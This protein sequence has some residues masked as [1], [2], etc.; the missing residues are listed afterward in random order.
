[1]ITTIAN[2]VAEKSAFGR[3]GKADDEISGDAGF[4]D[5]ILAQFGQENIGFFKQILNVDTQSENI[6]EHYADF[7]ETNIRFLLSDISGLMNQINQLL[8]ES[9]ASD[10][11]INPEKIGSLLSFF[12]K[13][14][15]GIDNTFNTNLNARFKQALTELA[16]EESVVKNDTFDKN[17]NKLIV[18]D[19]S[20]QN[21]KTIKISSEALPSLD[22]LKKVFEQVQD[23]FKY[24]NNSRIGNIADKFSISY[25]LEKLSDL[26]NNAEENPAKLQNQLLKSFSEE[27]SGEKV[28]RYISSKGDNA[29]MMNVN[30]DSSNNSQ[31]SEQLV[32]NKLFNFSQNGESFDRPDQESTNFDTFKFLSQTIMSKSTNGTSEFKIESQSEQL[33]QFQV[34]RNVRLADLGKT[35]F[36][37]MRNIGPES[38]GTARLTLDPASL[39]TVFVEIKMK[40]NTADLIIKAGSQEAIKS[41][42]SQIGMLKE[43]LG[44]NGIETNKIEISLSEK[45]AEKQNLAE[46]SGRNSGE[47]EKRDFLG[48]FKKISNKFEI[49]DIKDDKEIFRFNTGKLIEK[50]V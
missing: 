50:Y 3:I 2:G 49:E 22:V 13:L 47:K 27:F 42:E 5:N 40:G 19:N 26:N 14:F 34:I 6:F 24:D 37:F 33:P 36:G 15:S 16:N 25:M 43:K 9:V 46:N 48:S 10:N 18:L 44:Q 45:E 38:S 11:S 4:F 20:G 8:D 23:T 31:K 7:D 17:T 12:D 21:T 28:S 41:I 29:E 32:I 39:G 30:G 35:V 1:M